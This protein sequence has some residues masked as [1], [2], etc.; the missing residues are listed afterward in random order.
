M[1]KACFS[2]VSWKE[3]FNVCFTSYLENSQSNY[4]NY[5]HVYIWLSIYEWDK[6]LKQLIHDIWVKW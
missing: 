2:E 6:L 1:P 3:L 5:V 4:V